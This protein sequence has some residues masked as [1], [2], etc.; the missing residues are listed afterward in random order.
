LRAFFYDTETTGL[1]NFKTGPG[2]DSWPDVVQFAGK[3]V[4]LQ[5]RETEGA[6]HCYVVP[7]KDLDEKA[8]EVNGLNLERLQEIGVSRRYLCAAYDGMVKTTHLTICHNRSFDD[9]V[10]QTAYMR[11][12]LVPRQDKG[13]CTKD[14]STNIC[15]VPK[16]PRASDGRQFG[17]NKWPTLTEA[18][19]I[20]VRGLTMDMTHADPWADLAERGAIPGA[21]DA[22]NDVNALIEIFWALWD[23]GIRP[24]ACAGMQV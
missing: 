15:K 21:H 16:K 19:A 4:N 23:R 24:N 1:P 11:E 13:F 2:H 12:G 3:I 9:A 7:H 10:M 20:L 22:L 6:L 8:A 14:A 18:H 5:T 17:G